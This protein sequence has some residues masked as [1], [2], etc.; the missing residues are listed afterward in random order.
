MTY[1]TIET[2]NCTSRG[3]NCVMQVASTAVPILP[4]II[5]LCLFIIITM[6]TY[7][8]TTRRLG[9]G[10]LIASA[11]GAGF[12]CCVV[13]YL[14]SLIPNFITNATIVPCIVIE[15]ILVF[16]LIGSRD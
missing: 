14:M 5:L 4:A 3:I 8:A 6:A 16:M 9:R 15:I 1:Q 12:V 10:D 13:A 11:T 2:I 7:Y